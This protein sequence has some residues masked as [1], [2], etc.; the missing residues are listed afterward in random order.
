MLFAIDSQLMYYLQNQNVSTYRCEELN[1]QI[2]TAI[3]WLSDSANPIAGNR[4]NAY[5]WLGNWKQISKSKILGNYTC[6]WC[7]HDPTLPCL[8]K[9]KWVQ[10][11]RRRG[12]E[13]EVKNQKLQAPRKA[14]LSIYITIRNW[15]YV[16]YTKRCALAF[17]EI[18]ELISPSAASYLPWTLRW[19]PLLGRPRSGAEAMMLWS[20]SRLDQHH[21]LHFPP[22]LGSQPVRSSPSPPL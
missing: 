19:N 14:Q 17:L 16:N 13:F 5:T 9:N 20:S 15:L 10:Q 21:I 12:N 11:A 22:F 8:P 18:Q 4:K 7:M 1:M 3:P 6:S 2:R